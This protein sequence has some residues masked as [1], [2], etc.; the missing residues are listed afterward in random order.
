MADTSIALSPDQHRRLAQGH[1]EDGQPTPKWDT[2]SLAGAGALS[3]TAEDVLRYLEANLGAAPEPLRAA[4]MRCQ[5]LRRMTAP[6]R[7]GWREYA[8]AAALAAGGLAVE[9]WGPVP[10]G[11]L[12]FAL[13]QFV[14]I[15]QFG[16]G[17]AV[18]VFVDATIVRLALL[19]AVMHLFGLR[20]WWIPNWLDDKLPTFDVEGSE[21]EHETEGLRGP[22]LAEA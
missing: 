11:S 19:P 21:F 3:S 9:K 14:I 16:V 4:L 7:A 20:T 15:K 17:L 6:S 5:I 1:D 2:P 8:L 13:S 10:P 22:R 18:A 12:T